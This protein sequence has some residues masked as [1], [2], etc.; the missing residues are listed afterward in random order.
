MGRLFSFNSLI[1]PS[2][3]K[4]VFYLLVAL[5][6][7]GD[8]ISM[9]SLSALGQYAG[10]GLGIVA[11]LLH[12][13]GFFVGVIFIRVSCEMIMVVFMIRDELAWQREHKTANRQE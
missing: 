9:A 10:H 2:I 7:L 11:I 13:I 5:L 8:L 1:T 6:A 12:V 3:I 4:F